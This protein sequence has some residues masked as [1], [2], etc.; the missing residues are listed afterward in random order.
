MITKF[1]TRS[2]LCICLTPRGRKSIIAWRI[3]QGNQMC[4][5]PV[6]GI[7]I[8]RFFRQ[9]YIIQC[10]SYRRIHT[11]RIEWVIFIIAIYWSMWWR[12]YTYFR[13][14]EIFL[15]IMGNCEKINEQKNIYNSLHQAFK[16]WLSCSAIEQKGQN[17]TMNKNKS[18]IFIHSMLRLY[19]TIVP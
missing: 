17:P 3:A 1:R 8:N 16:N 5:Q 13:L 18:F 2:T 9:P 14:N 12:V 10:R 11:K 7:N 4:G 6:A 15:W 19:I